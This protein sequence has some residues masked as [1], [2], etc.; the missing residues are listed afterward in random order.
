[1]QAYLDGQRG[2]AGSQYLGDATFNGDNWSIAWQPTKFNGV[3]H[4]ILWIYARSAVTGEE[5]LF[6]EE[7][8]ISS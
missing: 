4:H 8:N 2:V 1:V 3:R 7:V 6:Q 5:T